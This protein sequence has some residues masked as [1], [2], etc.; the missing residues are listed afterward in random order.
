MRFSRLAELSGSTDELLWPSVPC[1]ASPS[2]YRSRSASPSSLPIISR[3]G[4]FTNG[5]SV[6]QISFLG[7]SRRLLQNLLFVLHLRGYHAR[8]DSFLAL[9]QRSISQSVGSWRNDLRPGWHSV[10][11][12]RGSAASHK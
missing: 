3:C 8:D 5:V 6:V 12:T 1:Y 9:C 4:P 11:P 7:F 2:V 10:F